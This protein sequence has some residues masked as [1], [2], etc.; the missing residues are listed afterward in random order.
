MSAKYFTMSEIGSIATTK[1]L[2]TTGIINYLTFNYH[3]L[4]YKNNLNRIYFNLFLL[5][6]AI[7]LQNL[8]GELFIFAT[9]I[10]TNINLE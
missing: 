1:T 3:T 6:Y 9:T 4:L 2:N 10:Q 8:I 5:T 7:S